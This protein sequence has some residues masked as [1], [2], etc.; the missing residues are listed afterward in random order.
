MR[1]ATVVAIVLALACDRQPRPAGSPSTDSGP[2][3]TNEA[4]GASEAPA[5]PREPA[6]PADLDAPRSA[7]SRAFTVGDTTAFDSLF[8][9]EGAVIDMVGMDAEPLQGNSG[10]RLFA[11]RVASDQ[12]TAGPRFSPDTM[13]LDNGT[14]RESGRWSWERGGQKNRG[15]YS[16][17]WRR[18][19]DG[20]W[21]VAEYRFMQR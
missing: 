16:M 14:A 18:D 4:P 21:R 6:K 2:S 7:F 10:V 15:T 3:A 19:A 11:R 12:A 9:S 17:A 1:T 20:R 13:Q 5:A 8:V